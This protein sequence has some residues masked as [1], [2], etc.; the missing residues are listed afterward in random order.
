MA[1]M[2][3]HCQIKQHWL[4]FSS[5]SLLRRWRHTPHRIADIVGH[6]QRALLVD[7]DADRPSLRLAIAVE[8]TGQHFLRRTRWLA[9]GERHEDHT[10]AGARLAIP[11]AVLA[12]ES[13]AGHF[14]RKQ[15][16]GVEGQSERSR[17]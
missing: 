12:D 15:M 11:R 3:A 4:E 2:D 7:L 1:P 9:I 6:Q 16:A 13:T 17:V 5:R 10:V 8:E 14:R